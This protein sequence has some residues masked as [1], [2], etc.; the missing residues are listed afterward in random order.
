[1]T[2]AEI[3]AGFAFFRE[4]RKLFIASTMKKTQMSREEIEALDVESDAAHARL[5]GL[6]PQDGS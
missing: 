4:M 3:A 1:M 6:E 5:Q 2:A